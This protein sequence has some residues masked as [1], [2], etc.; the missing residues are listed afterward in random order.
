M[1]EGAAGTPRVTH[2]HTH[3]LTEVLPTEQ[4][5]RRA[6]GQDSNYANAAKAL[7]R[8]TNKQLEPAAGNFEA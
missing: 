8:V 1:L 6:A 3:T 5:H 4:R 2:T 7:L